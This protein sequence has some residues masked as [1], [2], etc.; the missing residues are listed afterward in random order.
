M[1]A[2][3]QNQEG[4]G[5]GGTG[6]RRHH[7]ISAV[8]RPVRDA[9]GTIVEEGSL[10]HDD[11]VVDEDWEGPVGAVGEKNAGLHRQA[12]LPTNRLYYRNGACDGYTDWIY[13]ASLIR[14]RC[15]GTDTNTEA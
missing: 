6:V 9:R 8:S 4:A 3:I 11:E 1:S 15:A 12:S 13:I 5:G 7:T 10:S 2:H 14:I